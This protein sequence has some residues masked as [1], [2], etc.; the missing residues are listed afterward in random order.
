MAIE[1]VHDYYDNGMLANTREYHNNVLVRFDSWN[2]DGSLSLI[3]EFN[4][5]IAESSLFHNNGALSS[6]MTFSK[7]ANI[8]G[9]SIHLDTNGIVISNEYTIVDETNSTECT[10]KNQKVKYLKKIDLM[11]TTLSDCEK[12]ELQITYGGEWLPEK[13]LALLGNENGY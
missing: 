5:G 3:Q 11:T 10:F 4:G 2:I 12:F 7:L 8:F 6:Y 13:I 1:L 9:E